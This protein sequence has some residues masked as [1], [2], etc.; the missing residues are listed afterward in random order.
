M[1]QKRFLSWI[2][3]FTLLVGMFSFPAYAEGNNTTT[4][5]S[6]DGTAE[7]TGSMTITLEIP[8]KTPAA[9]DLTY[10]APS[11]LTY[12]GSDKAATVAAASGVTGLGNI[13]VKYY[14]DAS[15]TTEATPKNVGTYYVGA[16]VVEGDQYAA[17]TA[18]LYGDGWTFTITKGSQA[19]PAAPAKAN[20][21]KDSVTLTDVDG[22]EYSK[23]GTNWQSGTEF[24]GLTPGT[25]YTFYQ[26]RKETSNLN[27]SPASSAAI[28]TEADT[29][30]MTITLVINPSQTITAEDVTATYGDTDATVSA[31][32]TD[33]AEN[34]GAISYAVKTGSEDYISVNEST[35][36][37]T[38]K[39]A[40]TAIVIVTAAE[41]DTYA[42]ATKEVS[43]TISPAGVTLTANSGTETYDGTEKSVNGFTSSVEG[44]TF[45]GVTASGSGTNAGTYDVTFS[46]VTVNET[47][48]STG[49]YVVTGTT[50]GT[51]MINKANASVTAPTALNLTYTG[52]EQAL[53]EAG[54]TNDGDLLYSTDG[55][56]Y[57]ADIPKG[58]EADTY[59]VWYK[60]VGD[61]NH[62]DTEPA[63]FDVIISEVKPVVSAPDTLTYTGEAQAL[64]T[65]G[66]VTGG[67][68]QY[69]LGND[70]TTAP[71]LESFTT[72]VPTGT[73]A[74]DYFVWY[75][76]KGDANHNDVAPACIPVSIAKAA[77]T[78]TVSITSWT[79]GQ[80][81]NAPS[82]DGN[83]GS[84]AVTYEY[85]DKTGGTY[86]AAVPANAG[87][88]YVKATV[89]ETANYQGATTQPLSFAIVKASITPTVSI[90]GWTYGEAANVPSVD[91]NPGG[92]EVSYTYS[93]AADGTFTAT[94]PTNAGTWFVK[95]TVAETDNYGG[96][97]SA[98]TSFA[99][100]KAAI[101][102]T[103]SITGWTYGETANAPSVTGNTGNGAV[104]YEYS[105]KASEG[106][107]ATVPSNAGSWYVRAIV[108]ETDNYQGATTEPKSFAIAKAAITPTASITGWTYGQ[109]ANAPSVTGNTGNG[110]VTYEYS[111]KKDGTFTATVPTNA[112]TWYVKATV[113]ETDNYL[114]ATTEPQSFAIAKAAITITADN[115]SSVYGADIAAL[116]WKVGGG[117]VAGDELGISA[118]TTASKTSNVGS[119]P[120]TVAWNNN[121]NYTA[122]LVNG[123]YTITK[124][125]SNKASLT[126][127]QKPGATD[128]TYTG[129]PLP[130]ATAPSS[131]PAGY[132]VQYSIDGGKTWTDAI[133]T[134]T[135]AGSYTVN[136]KYVGDA[137][138]NDFEG[139]AIV[140]VI[141]AKPSGM[142]IATMVSEGD[143]SLKLSWV[144]AEGVGGYDIYLKVCDGKGNYPL[145]ATV[146][147]GNVTS[148]TVT[149][150]AK[151]KSYKAYVSPWIMNGGNKQYVLSNSPT[152][153][154]YT[155]NGTK[156]IANPGSLTLKTPSMTVKLGKTKSIKATVKTV[157]KGN[158]ATHVA[159]LRYISSNT[160]VATVTSKG[161]VKAVG[162]GSCK[163]YVLTTNG[164]WKTVTVTV[165]TNPTKVSISKPSKTM[166][167]GATQNLGAKV[168]L[169]PAKAITT[170]S[171]KSSNPAVAT[172][173]SNGVVTAIKKGKT[174]ITV[175]TANGKKAKVTI[176]V[177]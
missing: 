153:H 32:V 138:H 120:I 79:Y 112:G 20:A 134:G 170:L 95:A 130:L 85:S 109:T 177:K 19:A 10:T 140:S 106:Y 21:T 13:T 43:V 102:P 131:L 83:P 62:N 100:A 145:V 48:D 41:T 169:T 30:A 33:P 69:A 107:S 61:D 176:K 88:W 126:D 164:I 129:A 5:I 64:V 84:G 12:S 172:V 122:T 68:L 34:G 75:R 9:T 116:T 108:A 51:L 60:V 1:R 152:V 123:A 31:S 98:A 162:A 81:A 96:A 92:G 16:T 163:I 57:S 47:K 174:V 166:K 25:E 56:N 143:T 2:M 26:R 110:A 156:K 158:L 15:R 63:H 4:T 132:A 44:L 171:W 136:V 39:K 150:L 128:S 37:L 135:D 161:K 87:T 141:N 6:G 148:Y 45:T 113:A 167:V 14:S 36:A 72:T 90:T 78:P 118:S 7:K 157:K 149:G 76:I 111:D 154:A 93:D 73:D 58:T 70:A 105:D 168:K 74:G 146:T 121:A 40:G 46:G 77:I 173:D 29:Y 160:S 144:G 124:A 99:I 94:V 67:E 101:A 91:G 175:T 127:A 114:G 147:G 24:T 50:N 53:V 71:A 35:G 97:T 49:N 151:N 55:E 8:K 155:G 22:C 52:Q 137:N 54:N 117:Y 133:P 125:S 28:S 18:V 86:S 80:S 11:D 89:A 17:S 142:L 66:S 27:A 159:K 119:Y 59:T 23:D 38:I 82:V 3:V 139:D 104:T 42:A 65:G 103:V 165:D 115:K